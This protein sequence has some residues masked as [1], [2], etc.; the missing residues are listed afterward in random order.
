MYACYVIALSLAF[1][2]TVAMQ[3][4]ID[5]IPH[6]SIKNIV[7]DLGNVLVKWDPYGPIKAVF[8]HEPDPEAFFKQHI[9]PEIGLKMNIGKLT[10]A[11]AIENLHTN[12][13]IAPEQG[14]AL[15][16]AYK[17]SL[18]PIEGSFE[19]LEKLHAAGI[20]LY[21]CTDNIREFIDYIKETY[22]FYDRFLGAAVSAEL[23]VT[24]PNPLMYT[25]L[26][27]TYDL[28]PEQTLFFDDLEGNVAGAQAVGMHALQFTTA[29]RCEQQL[30]ALGLEF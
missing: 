21:A 1:S 14:K 6:N 28:V 19:L 22:T 26:L 13:N 24:K 3:L 2:N 16:E 11:E 29:A 5:H 8:P 9:F 23:G 15:M 17:Q 12:S 27:D 10:E 4:N 18:Q 30:R 20:P 25:Y 7:F